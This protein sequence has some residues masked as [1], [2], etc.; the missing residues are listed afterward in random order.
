MQKT[1]QTQTRPEQTRTEPGLS[2]IDI[3][4]LLTLKAE[5]DSGIRNEDPVRH[6]RFAY[7]KSLVQRGIIHD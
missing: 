3:D 4:R 2:D 6:P 5:I 7:I 1:Q